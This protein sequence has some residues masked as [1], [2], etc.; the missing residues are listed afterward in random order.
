MMPLVAFMEKFV[1]RRHLR[2]KVIDGEEVSLEYRGDRQPR[3]YCNQPVVVARFVSEI[4]QEVNRLW[5]AGSIVLRGQTEYHGELKP[6][7]LRDSHVPRWT[8]QNRPLVDGSK[9]AL[10]QDKPGEGGWMT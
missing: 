10:R 9:P 4:R 3:I 6:A 5:K 1:E 7:L 8:L 2:R